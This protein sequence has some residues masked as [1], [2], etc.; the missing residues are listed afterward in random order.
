VVLPD[1]RLGLSVATPTVV[2]M[3]ILVA[4]GRTQ[5]WRRND[6]HYCVE[7]EL[8]WVQEPC[9]RDRNDSDGPCGCG[10]GFAG[11]ASH[12][13]TTTAM[14]LETDLTREDM[15][16]AF[17]TSLGDGG[18]PVEWAGDVAEENFAIAACWPAGTVVERRLDGFNS[19]P[20][21]G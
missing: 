13:A 2:N 10:R 4:T 8:V 6:Y 17:K 7:G 21:G 16:L 11:A 14:V 3:K 18:W 19:R 9:A 15:V 5:G 20:D 12:R 1:F